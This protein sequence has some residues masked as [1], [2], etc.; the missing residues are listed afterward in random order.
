M[1]FFNKF[2]IPRKERIKKYFSYSILTVLFSGI[3]YCLLVCIGIQDEFS[4]PLAFASCTYIFICCICMIDTRGWDKFLFAFFY[5]SCAL[6]CLNWFF[7]DYRKTLSFPLA[8]IFYSLMRASLPRELT[9]YL[10][11]MESYLIFKKK[12]NNTPYQNKQ[13]NKIYKYPCNVR[14]HIPIILQKKKAGKTKNTPKN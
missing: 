10:D 3:I 12:R 1:N 6:C 14:K 13:K 7:D 11:T 2:Y 8:F 9:S 4:E 5:F